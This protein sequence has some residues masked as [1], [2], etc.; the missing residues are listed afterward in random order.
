MAETIETLAG[1]RGG[2]EDQVEL[3]EIGSDEDDTF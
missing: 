2:S 3:E 1:N